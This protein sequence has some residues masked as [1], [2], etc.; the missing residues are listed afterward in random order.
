VTSQ[1]IVKLENI[2]AAYDGLTVLEGISLSVR[3]NDFLGII[4]PN[5]G[6]KTTL[7]K[8][9]LGLV[10]PERGKI[11][12]F[13][14]SPKKARRFLG[15]VPQHSRFDFDFPASV[16]EVVLMG[17]YRHSGLFKRYDRL[18]QKMTEEALKRVEM[19]E[20]W[21]RQI[22]KLSQGQQQRVLLARALASEPKLLILDEPTASIDKPMETGLYDLLGELK[23]KMAIILVSHDISAVSV[24]VDKIACLNRKL[25]YHNSKEITAEELTEAYHCPVEMIAHGVPHRVLKKHEDHHD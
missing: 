3:G 9:I 4:G 12:V 8:L 23:K 19:W 20:L 5:G 7:L 6:G 16:G 24:H 21:D 17:R 14:T 18:D 10:D 11:E 15:Y 2:W 1:E 25:F 22:G 13:G